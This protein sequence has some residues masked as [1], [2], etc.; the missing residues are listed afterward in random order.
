MRS[1]LIVIVLAGVIGCQPAEE[2]A[3][4]ESTERAMAPASLNAVDVNPDIHEVEFENDLVRVIRTR[5]PAGHKSGMHTHMPGVYVSLNEDTL[6]EVGNTFDNAGEEH[7]TENTTDSERHSVMVELKVDSG[8]PVEA[9]S[10]DAVVVDGEH[11]T[12]EFENDLVRVVRMTYP[13]GYATPEHNHYAGVNILLTDIRATS[14]PEGEELEPAENEAGYAAW[15]DT[16]EPHIT[17]NLGGEMQLIRVEL[18][19]Q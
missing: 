19:I 9:P 3:P 13:E 15:A 12:I 5:R 4:T 6:G 2:P 1:V 14:G 17:T 10:H 7:E 16:G 18:K 8:T 11:H